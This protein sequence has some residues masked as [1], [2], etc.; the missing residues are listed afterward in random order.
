M[1]STIPSAKITS[2]TP[3]LMNLILGEG[4][5]KFKKKYIYISDDGKVW[6]GTVK[7]RERECQEG[8]QSYKAEMG[9]KEPWTLL[10]TINKTKKRTCPAGGRE[11]GKLWGGKPGWHVRLTVLLMFQTSCLQRTTKTSERAPLKGVKTEMLMFNGENPQLCRKLA[12][13]NNSLIA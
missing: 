6:W 11:H 3:A 7:V 9:E 13:W 10:K 5:A 2:E 8:V 12:V 4:E 1:T